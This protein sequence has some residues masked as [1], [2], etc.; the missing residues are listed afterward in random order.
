MIF[1]DEKICNFL[2]GINVNWILLFKA[3]LLV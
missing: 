3:R 2:I 1:V